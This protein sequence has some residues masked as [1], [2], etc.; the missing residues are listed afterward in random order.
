L[1]PDDARGV[2]LHCE[3]VVK[4]YRG[5]R[6]FRLRD[7]RVAPAE[8]VVMTGFD[9][10]TAELFTNLVNGATLPDEGEVR[11]A[12]AS[13]ASVTSEAEWLTSL[14]RFGVVT[15]RA[16]L[17]DGMTVLQN[18]ALP[19]SIEIEP[20]SD[21]LTARARTLAEEVGLGEDWWTRKV[22][23]AGPDVR[24]R[25]RLARAIALSPELLLLEHPTAPLEPEARAAY[26]ALVGEVV[27]RRALTVVACSQDRRFAAAV[28][29]RYLQLQPAT[30]ELVEIQA[31]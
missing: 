13:T 30:G 16:V 29:T 28:A 21:E 11:V 8:R 10:V 7:L 5:L 1:T 6:P 22:H 26:A 3:G 2:L 9:V 27:R 18:I 25:I 19:L 17:L 15:V 12:G 14:D 4:H 24:M 23:E 31:G 20:M